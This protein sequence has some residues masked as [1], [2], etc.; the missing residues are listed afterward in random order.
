MSVVVYSCI[1]CGGSIR[2]DIAG[3]EFVC[4]HCDSKFTLDEMNK[5]FPDDEQESRWNAVN[6][7]AR[8]ASDPEISVI[9]HAESTETLVSA[10]T[11]PSCGTEVMGGGDTLS[12]AFCAYCGNPVTITE[13]LLSGDQ[14]PSRMIPFKLTEEEAISIFIE[15]CKG[16][17]LLPRAFRSNVS[18]GAFKSVY[19]PFYLYDSTCAASVKALCKN[20]KTWRDNDYKYTKTDTYDVR[21]GGE[22]AFSGVP[23]DASDKIDDSYMQ[24]VEPFNKTGAIQFSKKYLSGHFAESATSKS[25]DMRKTLYNRLKPASESALISTI[26]GYDSVSV[27]T[28]NVSLKKAESEYVMLPVWMLTQ[29]L[30]GSPQLYVINGQTGKFAGKLPVDGKYARFLFLGMAGILFVILFI[31]LE[32]WAWIV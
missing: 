23:V 1:N 31:L 26:R 25:A 7:N 21:R 16:K 4:D 24:A 17:P 22:I 12:A 15:K 3:K 32:V 8:Q 30:N 13:K 29:T 14:F 5:A 18:P 20:V 28:S 9:S 6:E 27:D 2:Y 10:Y 11:C 19:V